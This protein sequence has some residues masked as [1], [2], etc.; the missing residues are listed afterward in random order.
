MFKK[1]LWLEII[2]CIVLIFSL[3]LLF[4][5]TAQA[6][7]G[8]FRQSG[9]WG[10][11]NSGGPWGYGANNTVSAG[12]GLW[13]MGYSNTRNGRGSASSS[14]Q[15]FIGWDDDDWEDFIEELQ[16]KYPDLEN[17]DWGNW[18]EWDEDDW[19]ALNEALFEIKSTENLTN[20]I[21]KIK[22][23][24][25]EYDQDDW[26]DFQDNWTGFIEAA[27][28][29]AD[30]ETELL[31]AGFADTYGCFDT[32][33]SNAEM[34]A[35][36]QD[37]ENWT[38][39]QWSDFRGLYNDYLDYEWK[40]FHEAFQSKWE[41]YSD[42][43]WEDWR[44]WTEEDWET[45][46]TRWSSFGN[47]SASSLGSS[48]NY[49]SGNMGFTSP[50]WGSRTA[51]S[52]NSA[53]LGWGSGYGNQANLCTVGS[54]GLTNPYNSFS[55]YAGFG[56]GMPAWGN[57]ET[58]AGGNNYSYESSPMAYLGWGASNWMGPWGWGND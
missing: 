11:Y 47:T 19:E 58:Y 27:D 4:S 10:G 22:E 21:E 18:E 25:N 26:E 1:M 14:G 15:S 56:W 23:K 31:W 12:N 6:Q 30:N 35:C 53:N 16:E 42:I 51:N 13:N 3:N 34:I 48:W 32:A 57:S 44:D 41:D 5:L 38:D 39:E 52:F 24:L 45:C 40:E 8:P 28:A 50:A 55:T 29:D 17:I 37:Y 46:L 9:G 43:D 36:W 33:A 20:F 2:F 54:C 7:W 49:Y